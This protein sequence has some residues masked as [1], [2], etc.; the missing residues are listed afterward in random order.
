MDDELIHSGMTAREITIRRRVHRIAEFYRHVFVYI[1]VMGALWVI[2]LWLVWGGTL[3]QKWLSYWAIWP[4]VGWGIGLLTHG[5]SVLPVWAFFTQD[6]EDK[7][8]RELLARD[9]EQDGK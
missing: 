4:T 2:N 9:A 1:I 5:I 6:W 8:V 3:P 7:K